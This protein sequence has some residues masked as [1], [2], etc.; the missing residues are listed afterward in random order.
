MARTKHTPKRKTKSSTRAC[1][2]P[3]IVKKYTPLSKHWCFT[4]NNPVSTDHMDTSLCTYAVIGNETGSDGTPHLQGYCCM[5]ARRRLSAMKKLMPRAHLEIMKGTS[6]QAS[7]YCKKDG[8]FKEFGILPQTGSQVTKSRW[9]F[10][11]ECSKHGDLESIPKDMLIRYYHAF[12]RIRQD[13]PPKL[14]SLPSTCGI[15]YYGPTGVGKSKLARE[16]YPDFYD[17][18][19]NKW[20]DGYRGQENVI[21]DDLSPD[22]GQ[23]LGTRMKRWTDHYPFPAEQKGTTVQIRPKQ[24]IVTSQYRIEEVWPSDILLQ[25]ALKRR[26]TVIE[27]K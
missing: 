26:F 18:P 13:N 16:K 27:M 21:I 5:K 2:R 23:Y 12:K 15:W 24:I 3:S 17:K 20:W 19:L 22:L 1:P 8:E 25:E 14:S 9:D 11:Y 7:D 10:A 6:L 4:I